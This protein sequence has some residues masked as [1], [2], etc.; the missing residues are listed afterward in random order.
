MDLSKYDEDCT[1]AIECLQDILDNI[2]STEGWKDVWVLCGLYESVDL[3]KETILRKA[4]VSESQQ[5]HI[6]K[7]QDYVLENL[8]GSNDPKDS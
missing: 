3:S 5:S 2:T 6:L 7:W 8:I 1:V 4:R